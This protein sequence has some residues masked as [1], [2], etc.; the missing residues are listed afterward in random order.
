MSS[1]FNIKNNII[2]FIKTHFVKLFYQNPVGGPYL[3]IGSI[4]KNTKNYGQHT[5]FELIRRFNT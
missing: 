5:V 4:N 1:T 3:T 2:F